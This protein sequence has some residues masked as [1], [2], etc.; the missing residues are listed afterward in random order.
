VNINLFFFQV[1]DTPQE[2]PF[3]NILQHL[4]GVDPRE[5]ASDL[6]WDVAETLVHRATLLET[7]EEASRLLGAHGRSLPKLTNGERPCYCSCHRDPALDNGSKR[8]QST[9]TVTEGGKH[10]KYILKIA[11]L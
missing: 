4:L 8:K 7:R 6:V 5:D 10:V 3:L 1:V 11:T 9:T 2:I